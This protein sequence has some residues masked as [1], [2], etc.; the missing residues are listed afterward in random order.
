MRESSH[1]TAQTLHTNTYV[2][3][4]YQTLVNTSPFVVMVWAFVVGAAMCVLSSPL[5]MA[6]WRSPDGHEA[7]YLTA[8]N[9]SINYV[10]VG[11]MFIGLCVTCIQQ[12]PTIQRQLAH[13]GMLVWVTNINSPVS[14]TAA[15]AELAAQWTQCEASIVRMWRLLLVVDVVWSVIEWYVSSGRPL[16][17]GAPPTRSLDWSVAMMDANRSLRIANAG[18]ALLAFAMQGVYGAFG[19][20][21]FSFIVCTSILWLKL[22]RQARPTWR[23]IPDLVDSDPRCGFQIFAPLLSRLILAVMAVY[24][25]FY[26]VRVWNIYIRDPNEHRMLE[27]LWHY[28]ASFDVFLRIEDFSSVSVLLFALII[29]II[30]VAVPAFT[31]RYSAIAARDHVTSTLGGFIPVPLRDMTVWPMRFPKLNLLLLL[32]IVG[33]LSVV[34]TWF[35]VLF[36]SL[37]LIGGIFVLVRGAV[38]DARTQA[39]ASTRQKAPPSD[40]VSTSS[41]ISQAKVR[42]KGTRGD[43]SEGS[44]VREAP[45]PNDKRPL[46]LFLSANPDPYSPLNVEKEQNRIVK[47]RNASKHQGTIGIESIPDLDLPEL[48]KSL[49][50]HNTKVVHF[51][52]H[53]TADGALVMR[54]ENGQA[55][56]MHPYGLADLLAQHD[57]TVRLIVLNACYSSALAELL[58]GDVSA[59]DQPRPA[60]PRLVGRS[61]GQVDERLEP[62]RIACVVGMSHVV[63][64]DAAILF[65]TTLYGALFDGSTIGAAFLIARA[66]VRARYPSEADAP[67]LMVAAGVDANKLALFE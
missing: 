65:A 49:R 63:T 52:G 18:F 32:A 15:D 60:R 53:G 19:C 10:L 59:D 33:L 62:R 58:T 20:L 6:F 1:T 14:D 31:L 67:K 26:T 9:W 57:G 64:D 22:S 12:F 8:I 45:S 35:G 25:S 4:L 56:P 17:L 37:S 28:V 66:L 48:A 55:I 43:P 13:R 38:S 5:Q 47:V 2:A 27:F 39:V 61:V 41:S 23:L 46:V 7:G 11:P 42:S 44:D 40:I 3:R 29:A 24:V 54:D 50:V 16:L 51:A 36:V 21:L 34:L 30:C